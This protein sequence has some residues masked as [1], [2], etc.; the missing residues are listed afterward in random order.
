MDKQRAENLLDETFNTNFDEA[1]FKKFIKEIFNKIEIA[2]VS[3]H[4]SKDYL[5]YIDSYQ[6]MGNYIDN[7]KKAIDVLVVKL[8]KETVYK[9]KARTK[10]R[11]IVAKYLGNNHKDAALVAFYGDDPEDWRFSFVKLDYHLEREESGKIK[12]VEDLTPAKRYSYLVGVN[13]PNHTCRRQFL[14]LITEEDKNPSIDEIEDAFSIDNVTKEFFLT[15]KELFLELKGS[16]DDII[17]ND[18]DV[19]VEFDEKSISTIDFSKKLLGQIVFI[20]FLQ[21]KGWLGVGK[22]KESGK[23][24]EWGE[25]PK[26]FVSKL[27]NK[28]IVPYENFFNDILEPLFYEALSRE[29]DDNFYSKLNCKIPFLNGGLFEPI[30]DYDWVNVKIPLEN[31]IFEKIL[32][33][34][35]RFNFTVKEDEPLDK[36]V[37]VDPEMLGKVF[38]NLLDVT[39]RKSRG[40]F[41]TPREIVHYMCQQSLMNYLETNT[42]IPV[43]DI[44]TFIQYGDYAQQLT[45]D[46][47]ADEKYLPLSIKNNRDRI[48]N[49]L[50]NIKIVDP[51]VG[52]GAFPMGMMN[53]IVKVRSILSWLSKEEKRTH[54]D[55]KRETIENCLYGVDIDSSAVDITKLRFWLSLVVDETDIK[56]IKPLPN[57][58]HRIMCGNSLLEEFEGVK[59]FDEQLLEVIPETDDFE[60]GQV[61]AE[62]E[63]FYLELG[64]IHTGKRKDNGRK[65]EIETELKKLDRKKKAILSGPKDETRQSTF[66]TVLEIRRKESQKKLA[67][68]KR[69]QKEFFNEQGRKRKRKLAEDID[70]I[71]WELV[72]ETLKEQGNE[73]AIQ[74]LAQYKKNK[75]KP[76]F[77]WKLY[78][79]DVFQRENP[80]FDV[81]IGNPPYIRQES[82][83][84][85]KVNLERV[86]QVYDSTS[87]IYTYFYEL[88]FNILRNSGVS[89][90]ITSN[91]WM[92]TAYGKKLRQFFL[93]NTTLMDIIDFSGKSIFDS[94]TV[95]TNILIFKKDVLAEG[96]CVKMNNDLP[97]R[98]YPS[99]L[100]PQILFNANSFVLGDAETEALKAKIEQQGIPL[101]DWDVN[102]YRGILTGF[103]Q[104]FIIDSATKEQLCQAD[105]KNIEI[106]KPILRGRNIKKYSCEWAGLWLIFTRRGIDIE[107][108]PFIKEYLDQFYEQIRPKNNN[109]STGRKKG[110][111]QWYEIQDNIAYYKEF[112]K[113]KIIYPNMTA[114]LP[115]YYDTRGFFS[116]DK[117][118]IITGES[119][120]YLVAFLNSN[121]FK[122]AFKDRF[123][124]LL[125][126]TRELRKVFFDKIPVKKISLAE[127]KPFIDLVD[128][129]LAITSAPDYPANPSKQSQV[130][131]L[132]KQIDQLVYKLYDLT[133]EEIQ[134][135][136]GFNKGK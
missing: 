85:L 40:A 113:E 62:I 101:K 92:R 111:Y 59:L 123:P 114:F 19:R 119:L 116:N 77:L 39:D 49:L 23:F 42:D 58:D 100:L 50:K 53:E 72:E 32:D 78:F 17:D 26:K 1:R 25:G 65:K 99:N 98:K 28:E 121:L 11:N 38:E 33:T 135:V 93:T 20:Y 87:D 115:F 16:L 70:I 95:D 51:A 45:I 21:K 36:E 5:N 57:L 132:E 44:E 7:S 68:L 94:A 8:K 112:E 12:S 136:E 127:E 129:I 61:D 18:P 76:F 117:S 128:Q 48:D 30:N 80:G 126:G 131:I 27:F 14:D 102:I 103:N 54:Y 133:P 120:K 29:Y 83:K 3:L 73:D 56:K 52:S 15:Y 108:Y 88:T 9:D 41:Y 122:Y 34:F 106:I 13:E 125:G 4:V 91:K 104:A 10:Q 22:D 109:E 63:R 71:E 74:K 96:H 134:I 55:L 35:D 89:T 79:A 86:Y 81:V 105:Q 46:S 130:K 97:N 69:L 118:F 84:D 47:V 67:E 6:R 2:P 43:T 64:E 90:F 31:Y 60:L 107:K 110:P 24:E 37:A 75:S 66:N 82:I 124:E